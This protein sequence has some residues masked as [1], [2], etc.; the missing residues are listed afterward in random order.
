MSCIVS[1]NPTDNRAGT[2]TPHHPCF[3][4]SHNHSGLGTSQD[5]IPIWQ[6]LVG[7]PGEHSDCVFG[8]T[9]PLGTHLAAVTL[10]YNCNFISLSYSSALK[11]LGDGDHASLSL[12]PWIPPSTVSG[13]RRCS[14]QTSLMNSGQMC[15]R[16]P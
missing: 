16:L 10:Y 13:T 15:Q 1:R 5:F 6:F 4:C 3:P 14:L 12:H 8:S 2:D 7:K 9:W 11:V